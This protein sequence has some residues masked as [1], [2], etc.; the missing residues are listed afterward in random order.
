MTLEQKMD[1]VWEAFKEDLS[2]SE[3]E[4]YLDFLVK[5]GLI[6]KT[7]KKFEATQ[8]FLESIRET[9]DSVLQGARLNYFRKKKKTTLDGILI[10][11]SLFQA[12]EILTGK[13]PPVSEEE[14]ELVNSRELGKLSRILLSFFMIGI[15]EKKNLIEKMLDEEV[16]DEAR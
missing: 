15:K 10:K 5:R 4:L 3:L 9:L 8:T 2:S 14:F 12:F 6:E 16:Y 13:K 11:V 7:D 1:E